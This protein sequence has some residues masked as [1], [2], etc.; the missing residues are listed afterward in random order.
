[1]R[2]GRFC[3]S[4]VLLLIVCA[5]AY[6]KEELT[7][8]RVD[9]RVNSVDIERNYGNNAQQLTDIVAFLRKIQRDNSLNVF[10]VTFRGSASPEGSYQLN[11]KLASGRL[12]ALESFVRREIEIPDSII[13][14]DDRYISWEYLKE[15][16][17]QSDLPQKQAVLDIINR[18]PALVPYLNDAEIDHR[19]LE[20]QALEEGEVWRQLFD[21]YFVHMR[22][23]SGVSIAYR[24]DSSRIEYVATPRKLGVE[25]ALDTRSMAMRQ[26]VLVPKVLPRHLHVKTNAL[27]W[28]LLI[29]NIAVEVD[30][31]D[32]WSVNLPV[33]YSALNYFTPTI[34][35]RTLATQPE[36]RYW[37]N[38]YRL[39][40]FAGAHFGYAQY[41]IAV[42]GDMRYQD[43][44]G[45]APALGGGISAGYRM[46]ISK[47]YRWFM[48]FSLGAGVYDLYYDTFYNVHNGQLID[49]H[50][51]TYWGIDNAAINISY[52]FNLK[53]R[54]K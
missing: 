3:I 35:F 50:R 48:E 24:I 20:L 5:G 12:A 22:N 47:D 23:A 34:K 49:T 45:E 14:R 18:E 8:I 30:L 40:F 9:F 28:G 1:M 17:A 7:E 52:R 37:P 2:I 21:R 33:Y 43:H 31:A 32:H 51:K 39:G 15:Q 19:I 46:P 16:V 41:N 53:R 54:Y 44:D 6:A 27:G 13:K 42:N 26:P 38:E 10:E 25:S 29:S 4:L 36:V 11:R